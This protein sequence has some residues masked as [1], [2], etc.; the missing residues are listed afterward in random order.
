MKEGEFG[1][2][3]NNVKTFSLNVHE[4]ILLELEFR[5]FITI[6]SPVNKLV[7]LMTRTNV[8]RIKWAGTKDSFKIAV[9]HPTSHFHGK[10]FVFWK[11]NSKKRF[12][13]F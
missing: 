2:V 6:K 12:R 5:I 10:A 4:K 13:I 3:L 1:A 8:K 7:C 11:R 9:P